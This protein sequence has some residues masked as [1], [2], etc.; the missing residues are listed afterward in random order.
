MPYV[1]LEKATRSIGS[2]VGNQRPLNVRPI[3]LHCRE[4]NGSCVTVAGGLAAH[5]N[6]VDRSQNDERTAVVGRPSTAMG[7]GG[8]MGESWA[9]ATNQTGRARIRP[10]EARD[11]GQVPVATNDCQLAWRPQART[12]RRRIRGAS[13]CGVLIPWWPTTSPTRPPF[14]ASFSGGTIC[15]SGGRIGLWAAQCFRT[16]QRDVASENLSAVA[17]TGLEFRQ[18]TVLSV[19]RG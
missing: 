18:I 13:D 2:Q 12:A 6:H 5:Q 11:R 4:S 15:G 8:E 7:S 19:H 16:T 17:A 9:M 1:H 14:A 3:G 10:H